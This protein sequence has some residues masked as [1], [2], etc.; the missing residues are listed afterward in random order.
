MSGLLLALGLA[1]STPKLVYKPDPARTADVATVELNM[2]RHSCWGLTRASMLLSSSKADRGRIYALSVTIAD[3][4]AIPIP[5]IS[6]ASA[7]AAPLKLVNVHDGDVACTEYQCPTGSAA[8]FSLD[9]AQQTAAHAG[10]LKVQVQTNGGNLCDVP[11]VIDQAVV[12][13]LETW[14]AKLPPPRGG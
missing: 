6:G 12:G 2:P 13:T 5:H 10:G 14:A 3:D 11:V 9:E 1:V 7:G 4:P 8:V